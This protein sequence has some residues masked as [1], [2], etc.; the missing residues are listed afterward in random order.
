[1]YIS[2]ITSVRN[3]VI[4]KR[5]WGRLARERLAGERLEGNDLQENIWRE[6]TTRACKTTWHFSRPDPL[7]FESLVHQIRHP[8]TLYYFARGMLVRLHVQSCFASST[9]LNL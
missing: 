8:F 4:P 9:S 2:R 7:T 3:W 5:V 6:T 1:M